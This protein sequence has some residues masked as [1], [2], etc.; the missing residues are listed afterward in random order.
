MDRFQYAMGDFSE[1]RVT[2]WRRYILS[3]GT[4]IAGKIMLYVPFQ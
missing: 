3:R 2:T 4:H 1:H